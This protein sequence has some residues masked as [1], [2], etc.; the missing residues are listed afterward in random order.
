MCL[1]IF[2]HLN[3]V[4][5]FLHPQHP[6]QETTIREPTAQWAWRRLAVLQ[7]CSG[8]ADASLPTFQRAIR[9]Q[10]LLPDKGASVAA[11][12]ATAALWEGMASAYQQ[13]GRHTA[14]LKVCEWG[15]F[16]LRSP[17]GYRPG[18]WARRGV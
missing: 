17:L 18:V 10:S 8:A 12:N 16:P 1:T 4:C 2:F 15:R 6:A 13:L 9:G 11:T 3:P 7:L 5:V 14:A